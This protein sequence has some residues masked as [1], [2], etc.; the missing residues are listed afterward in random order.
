MLVIEDG[1]SLMASGRK[2]S[3]VNPFEAISLLSETRMDSIFAELVRVTRSS[4]ALG[5]EISRARCKAVLQ[6]RQARFQ[7]FDHFCEFLIILLSFEIESLNGCQRHAI[8]IHCRDV[9]VVR[10][11]SEGGMKILSHGA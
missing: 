4:T 6:T 8:R 5:S 10:S 2:N 11:Y 3:T 9:M 7:R 1:N